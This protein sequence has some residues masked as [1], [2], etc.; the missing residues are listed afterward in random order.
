MSKNFVH[1]VR[2]EIFVT[3]EKYFPEAETT[4]LKRI[5]K[6]LAMNDGRNESWDARQRMQYE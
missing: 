3:R 5:N 2:T 4:N 1:A 6:W